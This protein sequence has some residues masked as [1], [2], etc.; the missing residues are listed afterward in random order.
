MEL[1]TAFTLPTD[2]VASASAG[3]SSEITILRR[4]RSQDIDRDRWREVGNIPTPLLPEFLD[5]VETSGINGIQPHYL[6]LRRDGELAGCA[7]VFVSTTDFSTFDTKLPTNAREAIKR[8]FPDFMRFDVVECG[9][10]T[11][12]GEALCVERE[13]DFPEAIA[14]LDA[15]MHGIARESGADFL[16]VRDIPLSRFDTYNTALKP[17]GYRPLLGFPN[18][19]ISIAWERL[20]DYLA[21]LDSKTRLKFKN[22]MKLKEKFDVDVSIES[23]FEALAPTFARLWRNVNENAGEYSREQLD[24]RFFRTCAQLLNDQCEA[25][26]FRH[27]GEV[28]AFMLNMIGENDYIV[29]DWGVDYGFEHYR[30]SNLYRSA[31]LLSLERA[32][33]LRKQRMELGITNYTPKMTLGA[34]VEPLAYFVKHVDN[35]RFTDTFAKLLADSIAQPDNTGHAALRRIA[36][37]PVDI[38]AIEARMKR[39]QDS[40]PE[41]DLFNRVGRYFRAETMRLGGI[42]GLYPE[43]DCAQ[44][45]SI[46][47]SDR[48][49][50]ILLGTNSYLGASTHPDVMT[51]A[52]EAVTRYGSGCSG[53]PLLNGTL[54]I[55]NK[56]ERELSAFMGCEAVALCSTGYQTNLAALSALLQPG[57]VAIMDARNHRSLFDGVRL[58]GADCLIHRHADMEHLER[59]LV[60]SKGRRRM[61]VTDSL[62]S[63]EGTV[64]DLRTICDLAERHGARLFVDESHAIGVLGQSGR[65]V[66]E[67]QGVS[68]RVDLVMGTFSKSFAA[69][70]GFVGGRYEVID[71]IKHNAGGHI[72]S[73]SLPAPIVET[74]RAVLRLIH[75]EPERRAGILERAKYMATSLQ[76]LGYNAPWH[77]SQIVPVVLGNYTLALAAY[78]RFM[79]HGVY[80]NP[81]GPPAVPEEASGF[82]TSYIATHRWEDLERALEVFRA[83]RGD[84]GI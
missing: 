80:V 81:V 55:H 82:R 83:H 35:P 65:G 10:F 32:I 30:Q 72:F 37:E 40:Y 71:F 74:V 6:E 5:T 20:E 69:L 62:F 59:V 79:Q 76:A 41:H 60:R 13:H 68:H 67:L 46:T 38:P 11:M 23:D 47:F 9:F 44:S 53:S 77:G 21:V 61:I 66:C 56:L 16:L 64:A 7:N 27:R 31:T 51:A 84:F 50:R 28:I 1:E 15:Q 19:A 78:K 33:N 8:W 17:L 57:D 12:I 26:V 42:Y 43:F 75:D 49:E 54:D 14:Q 3:L 34:S 58:S 24:E 45:S 2:A 63:M 52:R 22:S 4:R 36:G 18:S 25:L 39:E 48:R 70:G 29:L 73:A